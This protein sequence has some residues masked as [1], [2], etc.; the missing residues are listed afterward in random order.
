MA[1]IILQPWSADKINNVYKLRYVFYN[2]VILMAKKL[3]LDR[4]K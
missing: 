3:L 4:L 2:V 1:G